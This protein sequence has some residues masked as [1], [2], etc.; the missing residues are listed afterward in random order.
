V[1]SRNPEDENWLDPNES[2]GY[3]VRNTNLAVGKALRRNLSKY[4]M[5]LGQYYFMRTLWIEEGLSQR[6]LSKRVGTTEP[7]T[8]SVL[9]LLEK[10]GHVRRVRNR[11]DRRTINIFPTQK[12]RNLKNELLRM[13][14]NINDI[15]TSGLTTEEIET[16]KRL[17]RAMKQNLDR[18]EENTK[19]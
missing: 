7:T 11:R 1:T 2:A 14:T 12:G 5:T 8:A 16:L 4:G 17:M 6:E 18:D 10:N 15:A 9:R 13:A 19:C 3:L